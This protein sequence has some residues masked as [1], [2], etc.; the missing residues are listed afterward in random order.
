MK[1]KVTKPACSDRELLLREDVSKIICDGLNRLGWS[2]KKLAEKAG[3]TEQYV[4]R[5]LR[6]E[7]NLSL[8]AVGN[9]CF[10]LGVR[11]VLAMTLE[12]ATDET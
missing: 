7:A 2:R 6:R 11:P 9:L 12:G 10:A 4:G 1:H 3:Y 8:T 5:V